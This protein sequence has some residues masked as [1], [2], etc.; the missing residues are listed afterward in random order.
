MSFSNQKIVKIELLYQV[1]E[2]ISPEQKQER[3]IAVYDL[4][5]N[6]SFHL[7]GNKG[8]YH[9]YLSKQT[10]HLL[11]EIKS[12]K[13]IPINSFYLALGPFRKL[14]RD[15]NQICDSYYDAIRTKPPSQIQAI[16]V[17]RKALHDEGANLVIERLRGKIEINDDTARRLFTLISILRS[18]Q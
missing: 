2:N 3:S 13:E 11:F 9:L 10:R 17:G 4:M 7:I 12:I 16:D 5:E 15:Y 18:K 1:Q 6:N 8:P 14:I